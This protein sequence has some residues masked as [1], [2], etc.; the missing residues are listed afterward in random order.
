MS[1]III[2]TVYTILGGIEAVTWTDVIQGVIFIIGGLVLLAI[3][4]F[5][6]EAGACD[7]LSAAGKYFCLL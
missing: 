7:I 2:T 6:T 4:L 1:V 5:G 3:A